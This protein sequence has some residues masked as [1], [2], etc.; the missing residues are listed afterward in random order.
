M[1]HHFQKSQ[2]PSKCCLISFKTLDCI[3]WMIMTLIFVSSKFV[4]RFH[5]TPTF[6]WLKWPS[7]YQWAGVNQ[8]P[9]MHQLRMRPFKPFWGWIK[10]TSSLAQSFWFLQP[11]LYPKVFP[12]Y[13]PPSY[14]P[15]PS[16]L[17]PTYLPPPTYLTS[18][19]THI[20]RQ[21][22]GELEARGQN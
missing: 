4:T 17:P 9:P 20:H 12:S 2:N 5:S 16:Y 10:N 14:L 7:T 22:L 6:A 18:F 15:R 11:L 8:Q 19:C 1:L 3:V 21:S 13:L